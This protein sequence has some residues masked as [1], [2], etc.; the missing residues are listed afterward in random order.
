MLRKRNRKSLLAGSTVVAAVLAVVTGCSGNSTGDPAQSATASG[1]AQRPVPAQIIIL[2]HGEEGRL[3][4]VRRGSAASAGPEYQL[5][6]ARRPGVALHRRY[7]P[8]P[9]SSPS[10]CILWSSPARQR[11]VGTCR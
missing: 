4:L 2:R 6:G 11:R 1:Q 10:P 8:L 5:P 7:P 9:G 3:R